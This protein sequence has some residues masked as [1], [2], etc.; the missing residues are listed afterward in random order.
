MYHR[1]TSRLLPG[2]CKWSTRYCRPWYRQIKFHHAQSFDVTFMSW[3]VFSPLSRF[4]FPS[5]LICSID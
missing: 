3:Y 1:K 5:F 2:A 4:F